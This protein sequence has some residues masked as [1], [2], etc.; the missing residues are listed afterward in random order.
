MIDEG[1]MTKEEIDDVLKKQF[2]FYNEELLS[3]DKYQPEKAYFEKQWDG[4][5]QAPSEITIWDTG[6]TWDLLS[7]IGR[8]SVHHPPEFVSI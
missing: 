6:V 5:M 2:D 1:V 3:V 8:N 7:Y 4:F